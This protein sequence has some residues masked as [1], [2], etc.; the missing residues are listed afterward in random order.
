MKLRVLLSCLAACSHVEPKP[1]SPSPIAVASVSATPIASTEPEAGAPIVETFITSA[2]LACTEGEHVG[3]ASREDFAWAKRVTDLFEKG[4]PRKKLV[5]MFGTA[6]GPNADF[7]TIAPHHKSFTAASALGKYFDHYEESI[8]V[9]YAPGETPLLANAEKV[10][11]PAKSV[12]RHHFDSPRSSIMY[13]LLT[14]DRSIRAIATLDDDPKRIAKLHLDVS[15]LRGWTPPEIGCWDGAQIGVGAA[16]D[17]LPKG[18]WVI[19]ANDKATG[20]TIA[21]FTCDVPE[22]SLDRASC[23]P[24]TAT[25]DSLSSGFHLRIAGHATHIE[26]LFTRDGTRVAR[27][28]VKPSYSSVGSC[29]S[30]L[31]WASL[32]AP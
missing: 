31:D 20:A 32:R 30:A 2:H 5:C 8:E 1:P 16:R 21:E 27:R 23:T 19:D 18:R 12:V 28:E 17:R 6:T 29:T 3:P 7:V 22:D 24:P 10:F 4:L 14:N 26:L 11:G 9:T 25:V 15:D 13:V